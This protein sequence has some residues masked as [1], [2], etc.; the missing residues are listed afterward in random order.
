MIRDEKNYNEFE[1]SKMVAEMYNTQHNTM[2][3]DPSKYF[4]TSDMLIGYKDAPLSVPNEPAL[5]LMSKALKEHFTEYFLPI[6]IPD[7]SVD[8]TE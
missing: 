2:L 7:L 6:I 4:E 1:Y 5:Y 8:H 3:L